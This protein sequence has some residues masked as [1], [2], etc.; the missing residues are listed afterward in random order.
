MRRTPIPCE[1]AEW[2]AAHVHLKALRG[3]T[4]SLGRIYEAEGHQERIRLAREA[5]DTAKGIVAVLE[6][7][8][9]GGFYE[10]EPSP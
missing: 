5:L 4:R 2:A 7:I 8:A 10:K 1:L 9:N 3:F 6:V